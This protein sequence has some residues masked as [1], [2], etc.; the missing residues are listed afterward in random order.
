MTHTLTS[1]HVA[2]TIGT[3][4]ITA[5]QSGSPQASPAVQR[6]VLATLAKRSFL[7]LS[8]VSPKGRPHSAGVVYEWVDDAL[9]VHVATTSRKARNIAAT[10]H[11]GV[12]VPFRKLPVGPPFTIHFQAAAELIAMDSGEAVELLE[13]GRLQSISSHGELDMPEGSF[14][15][16]TPRGWIHSFGVGVK[17]LD[18][19][20]DP[21]GSGPRRFRFSAPEHA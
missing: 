12:T 16:L 4:T 6:K 9:W 2:P 17:T 7:T 11:A 14:L 21:I 15:K 18:L 20:R 13:A 1:N 3:A 5:A 19:I 10:P 8:T